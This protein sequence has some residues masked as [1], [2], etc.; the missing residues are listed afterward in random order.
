MRCLKRMK[1]GKVIMRTMASM[2]PARKIDTYAD[3]RCS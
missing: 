1:N 3:D 2:T